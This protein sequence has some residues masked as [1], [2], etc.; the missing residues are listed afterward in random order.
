MNTNRGRGS[1]AG[2]ASIETALVLGGALVPA[3][4]GALA[5]SQAVWTWSGVIHLT[6]A[7]ADYAATHC[8]QDAAGSNVTAWMQAHVP[9]MM[10]ARQIINGPAQISVQY[11]T[12]DAT[13]RQSVPFECLESCSFAC[14]PDSVTVTVSGYQFESLLRV[15]GLRAIAMPAFSTTRPVESLGADPDQG[16]AIP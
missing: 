1:E 12:H 4:F 13:T 14:A 2:A 7:G 9:P 16:Q 11:W 15:L 10:D 5:V 8:Y 6:R 3:I